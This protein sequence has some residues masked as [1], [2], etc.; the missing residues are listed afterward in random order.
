MEEREISLIDLLVEV[1]LH[2]RMFIVW[3]AV[4]AILLGAFSYV[5]S[6]STIQQTQAETEKMEQA[7]EEW[8][9]EEEMRNAK[10]VAAYENAY[11]SKVAYFAEASFMKIDANHINRGEVIIVIEAQ[12][13][14]VSC[15]I[16]KAY[17]GIVQGGEFITKVS[18]D[19]GMKL[20]GINET[21]LFNRLTVGGNATAETEN[22][23]IFKVVVMNNDEEKC[24]AMLESVLALLKEKQS[25]VESALGEHKLTVVNKSFGVV[26]DT[27]VADKQQKILNDIA[28][29]KKTLSD[30]KEK[31]SDVERQYYDLLTSEED[32]EEEAVPETA[33]APGISVKYVLLGAV[34]AAF[35]YAFVLFMIY[36]FTAKIRSTDNLQELYN[37]PQLG[38]IPADK[39]RKNIFGF[40]DRWILS[41]RN[42]NKRQFTAEEA[43]KLASVAIKMSAGKE[44]LNEICLVGCGLKERSLDVC[45]KMKTQLEEENIQ[46]HIL[47]NVLYDAQ[48]M[49]ELEKT[50]GA[51]LV[52]G[53][54]ATLYQEIAEELKILNRQEIKVLGGI[55]V[56]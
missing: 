46:V 25:D 34:M 19:V 3:M 54:G 52:E 2:W 36:I 7:P 37:I 32:V 48:A 26:A 44:T 15:D 56:E 28:T 16:E 50:K 47:N 30:E 21:V 35:L 1:L 51:V 14:Q 4:G 9:T 43:L 39:N 24:Q 27:T 40:V 23:S 31:L 6:G 5:R 53:A 18:E 33:P 45:E 29:M 20:S 55:L 12:D 38:L 22:A 13:H 17:E 8:F 10:Y 42:H 41:L 11:L 49:G